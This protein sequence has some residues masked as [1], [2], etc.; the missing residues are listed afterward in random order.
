ML[1][2]YFQLFQLVPTCTYLSVTC[3]FDLTMV[4][5]NN[6][7]IGLYYIYKKNQLIILIR[8][9]NEMRFLLVSKYFCQSVWLNCSYSTYMYKD[10]FLNVSFFHSTDKHLRPTVLFKCLLTMMG[11]YLKLKW[12]EQLPIFCFLY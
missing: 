11:I 7:V 3:H 9:D 5:I 10:L 4:I 6:R 8:S 12:L 2:C 1:L